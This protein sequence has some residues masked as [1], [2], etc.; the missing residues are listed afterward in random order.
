MKLDLCTEKLEIEGVEGGDSEMARWIMSNLHFCKLGVPFDLITIYM[1]YELRDWVPKYL[2][3]LDIHGNYE[4]WGQGMREI[5]QSAEDD[6][7]IT[8]AI[9]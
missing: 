4:Q 6:M 7:E 8:E 1:D 3:R 2:S 5:S 9:E